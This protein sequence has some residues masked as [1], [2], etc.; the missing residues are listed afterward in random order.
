[1]KKPSQSQLIA[2]VSEKGFMFLPSYFPQASTRDII[3]R[4]GT[5][6]KLPGI[7][8][9]QDLI[10]KR[11]SESPPNIYSG[12]YGYGSFPFH[13]DLAHWYQPPHFIVL[14]CVKGTRSVRTHLIDSLEIIKALGRDNLRRTL[15]QPRR[16]IQGNRCLLRILEESS[17][18]KSTFRWD[19]LFIKPSTDHSSKMCSAIE[20]S[21]S[22]MKRLDF[23]FEN[24]GDTLIVD[25]WRMLHGRSPVPATQRDRKIHRAYVSS[26][27]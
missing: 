17:L 10:P 24:P 9:I 22:K 1:M 6:E 26:L 16:P 5:I 20:K 25:N 7:D 11:A 3:S 18:D 15:V 13:T 12:N 8:E 14:R 23:L 21:I 4:F 19:S 2:A 27:I